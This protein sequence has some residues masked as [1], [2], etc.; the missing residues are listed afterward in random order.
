MS[1]TQCGNTGGVFMNL[2]DL[3]SDTVTWPTEDMREAMSKATVGDDFYHDDSTVK[4]LES[5]AASITGKEAGLFVPSG[6]FG[7]QL[8]LF[9]HCKRG[10]EVILDDSCHIVQ[11]E[12]GASGIIAGVQLRTFESDKGIF[13]PEDIIKRIRKG[14]GEQEPSTGLICLENAHSSGKVIPMSLMDEVK[15]ISTRYHIPVHLDGARLFN[16]ATA[17]SVPAVEITKNVDTVMFCL[18]K[19]LCAPAGAILAGSYKFIEQARK[20][21]NLLGGYM[22]QAGIL[23]SAGLIGI[24]EMRQ[25]LPQDHEMAL[26]LAKEL[27]KFD[28]IEISPEDTEINIVYF[29][30]KE[31]NID[32]DAFMDFFK[33]NDILVREPSEDGVFRLVTHYWITKKEIDKIIEVFRSFLN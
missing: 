25:R 28:C 29:K 14:T 32:P 30:F 4:E 21:R 6:T 7:N 1:P 8:A 10:Q 18:S 3:R 26:Y 27:E 20:N 13:S 5:Y 11:N 12:A 17:L 9:T 24:K 16:A 15:N 31:N 23:A 19:G 33:E 22:H 2:I